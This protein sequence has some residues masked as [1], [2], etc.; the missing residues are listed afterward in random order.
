MI[1]TRMPHHWP[2]RKRV[3]IACTILRLRGCDE[4]FLTT[5]MN[6]SRN[7]Q[8]ARYKAFRQFYESRMRH[9]IIQ[10]RLTP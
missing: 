8:R 2:G 10:R 7:Q 9:Q 3:L 1:A 5:Y 6:G 4:D